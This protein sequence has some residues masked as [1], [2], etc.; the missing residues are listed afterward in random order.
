MN[1]TD[2]SKA[3]ELDNYNE[4]KA[5]LDNLSEKSLEEK[6]TLIVQLMQ[7]G[8]TMTP[9]GTPLI[10][11]EDLEAGIIDVLDD[12]NS[13]E[14]VEQI[15]NTYKEYETAITNLNNT[16]YVNSLNQQLTQ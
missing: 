1:G 14:T 2:V 8:Q 4:M 12:N 15:F 10:P 7:I 16:Q 9:N 6:A 5:R 3:A 13:L 11:T